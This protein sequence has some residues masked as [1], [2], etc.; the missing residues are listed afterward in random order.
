VQRAWAG[1]LYA[2]PAA[3][4]G[5]SA[6]RA[7]EG[8]GR[9]K[10]REIGIHVAVAQERKV[11][12]RPGLRIE[13]RRSLDAI[14]LWNLGPPR[15]RYEEAVL[16]VALEATTGIDAIAVISSACGGRR[17]HAAR[18]AAAVAARPRVPRR[19]WITAVLHDVAEGTCSVLE[20]GYL[21]RVERP[22]GLPPALRQ[23]RTVAAGGTVYRD[24]EIAGHVVI[25]LDGRLFHALR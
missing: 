1:V 19:A 23:L 2:W 14:V 12:S 16:D 3:L 11:V 8:P 6:L 9:T 21:D 7:A 18:L 4:T 22:H 10:P 13:R 15:I 24:A 25:E 17:T 20:H 5:E